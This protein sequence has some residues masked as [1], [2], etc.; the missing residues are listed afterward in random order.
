[1]GLLDTGV[2]S[3]RHNAAVKSLGTLVAEFFINIL[4]AASLFVV[5]LSLYFFFLVNNI[6]GVAIK[7]DTV[8]VVQQTMTPLKKVLAPEQKT[9]I[10]KL[11]CEHLHAPDMKKAD[12]A[13]TSSN[14]KILRITL[15]S[16][17][18]GC[19]AGVSISVII[20]LAMKTRAKKKYSLA[21]RGIHYPDF[22]RLME[23]VA[24]L[25]M[26]VFIT[27]ILFLL[28]INKNWQSIDMYHIELQTIN[29]LLAFLNNPQTKF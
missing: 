12:E 6:E 25:T 4:L 29:T 28:V 15:Y 18:G 9:A 3:P 1:M 24:I 20:W 23:R 17:A 11:L 5:S 19:V 26:F 21:I 10:G 27:Q 2:F 7:M 22:G 8:R 16:I 13:T 14:Q